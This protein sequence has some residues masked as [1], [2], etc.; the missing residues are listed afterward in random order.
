MLDHETAMKIQE[1]LDAAERKRM[2]QVHQVAQGFTED[3]WDD[4]LARV[5]A[6]KDFVQQLQV[7]EKVSDED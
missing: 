6:D 5:A 2:T 4:I 3:E 1:E 7:G